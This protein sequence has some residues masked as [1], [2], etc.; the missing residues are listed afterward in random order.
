[1]KTVNILI[2]LYLSIFVYTCICL[3]SIFICS[4]CVL[5]GNDDAPTKAGVKDQWVDCDVCGRWT[6]KTCAGVKGKNWKCPKC[7]KK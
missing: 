7:V 4:D 1:M 6:H 2:T 3:Y 5:C